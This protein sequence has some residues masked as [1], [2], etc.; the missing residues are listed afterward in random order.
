MGACVE[1][2]ADDDIDCGEALDDLEDDGPPACIED[3]AEFNTLD[4][5]EEY[6]HTQVC[7]I[8]VQ[9][10]DCLNDCEGDDLTSINDIISECITCLAAGTCDEDMP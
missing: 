2:I 10:T 1:C 4:D 7:E 9:W 5:E 3:C 6:T 8:F